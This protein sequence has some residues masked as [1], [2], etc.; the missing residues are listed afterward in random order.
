MGP[1]LTAAAGDHRPEAWMESLFGRAG[2]LGPVDA[3]MHVDVHS[4]LPYD[5]LVKVDIASMA[6]SLEARSPFLDHHV[7]EFAARLPEHE[8]LRGRRGKAVLRRAFR[9]LLPVENVQ[10]PKMGFAVPV[11]E[12]LRG[13]LRPLLEDTLLNSTAAVNGYLDSAVINDLARRH[14]SRQ[15]DHTSQLWS[16]LMLE[17]WHREM[18]ATAPW[19]R[20]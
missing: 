5:L 10:R 12:W 2:N 17:C 15:A 13:P 20:A 14:L 3:A 9:E 11:G 1:A 7:M 18:G 16:L 4:Y 6:N 8:K 19:G